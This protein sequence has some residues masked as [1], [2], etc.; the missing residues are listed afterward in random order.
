[1]TK[2]TISRDSIEYPV[3]YFY[4]TSMSGATEFSDLQG[5]K[6]FCVGIKGTGMAALAEILTKH[7]AYLH[8]SDVPE[9]FYTDSILRELGIPVAE[10]F[11]PSNIPA[12]T[13]FIIHSAAYN[14]ETHPELIEG[15]KRGIPLM[16]YP[17]ALGKLSS[18]SISAGIAGTHGKTT[19]AALSATILRET[20]LSV[21]ALVGSA[22]ANLG[23]RST[24]VQGERYFVAET[25]EYRRNFLN[26]HPSIL[27]FTNIEADHLDYYR[28]EEDFMNAFVEYGLRLPRKGELIYCVDDPGAAAAAERISA[29]RPDILLTPY[30][31]QGSGLFAVE[32]CE[33]NPGEIVFMLKGFRN[34]CRLKVPGE[35]NVLNA[36][37]AAAVVWALFRRERGYAP[38]EPVSSEAE[39]MIQRGVKNFRGSRRRS[40]IVGE[41][42]GILFMDDYGH[43]PTEIE[44]TLSGLRRFYP[45][46]RLVVDFM[47]HTFSRTR[48]L[49]DEFVCAFSGADELIFHKIYAS[50]REES[51]PDVTGQKLAGAVEEQR[52]ESGSAVPVHYFDEVMDAETYLRERLRPGDLFLT[53]GAGDNWRIGH[54][55]YRRFSGMEDR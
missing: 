6:I 20:A 52:A 17:E 5:K 32:T 22:V 26:F 2:S 29:S 39:E 12:D 51:D 40:E 10:T 49:F 37:A 7:G 36:A 14:P 43:H 9:Q 50:A 24:L 16:T 1:M 19:T 4:Y 42:S 31:F 46:R 33:M 30:G 48:A 38:D 53:L 27:V 21:S 44:T 3:D 25:C 35:H 41:A 11:S 55:L 18:A 23:G 45:D 34:A 28:D 54:S 15:K 47:S 8:G 13:Q